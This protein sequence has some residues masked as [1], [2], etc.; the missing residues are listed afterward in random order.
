MVRAVGLYE[1]CGGVLFIG[2]IGLFSSSSSFRQGIPFML[3]FFLLWRYDPM[4]VMASSFLRVSRSHIQ[5][6]TTVG[7]T[8]L[9][10]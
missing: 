8:P 7:R 3:Q 4:W 2:F 5:R 10:G 6:C 9:D 1:R